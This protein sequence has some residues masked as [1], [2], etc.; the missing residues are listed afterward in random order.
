MV[1]GSFD[2]DQT[3]NLVLVLWSKAIF[4]VCGNDLFGIEINRTFLVK[5]VLLHI[6]IRMY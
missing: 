4:L 6:P 1:F 5:L 2:Y 3:F